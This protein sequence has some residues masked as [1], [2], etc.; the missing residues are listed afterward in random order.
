M[1]TAT[2]EKPIIID[3]MP[4]V[5]PTKNRDR[6]EYSFANIN[7]LGKCNLDCFFCLGKDLADE[8]GKYNQLTTPVFMLPNFD[9]FIGICKRLK[10]KNI[11]V[12]G[13]NTDALLYKDLHFLIKHLQAIG[14]NVGIRTN[15]LLADEWIDTLSMCRASVSYTLLTRNKETMKAITGSPQLPKLDKIMPAV[16]ARQRIA[17]VVTKQ[18][19]Y[20]MLQLINYARTLKPDYFQI[21]RISTDHRYSELREHIIAFDEVKAV[22]ASQFPLV[23]SYE[24]APIYD[25]NGLKVVLW[26]TVRTSANSINYYS[27]GVISDEYFIIEGYEKL[28]QID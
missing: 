27:N 4:M 8:F 1:T 19:Q 12:T 26:E 17:T 3:E 20:E 18:N 25:A 6:S 14:F 11:Y 28:V 7:F 16:K 5:L 22:I 15:G 21:R 9:E 23:S 2:L 24:G 13:Q 10:I